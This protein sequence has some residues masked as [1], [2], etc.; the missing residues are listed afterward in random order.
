M[1]A[2]AAHLVQDLV[3]NGFEIRRASYRAVPGNGKPPPPA[4]AVA[5]AAQ[6]SL[7]SGGAL[8]MLVLSTRL[9]LSA[10]CILGRGVGNRAALS[11]PAPSEPPLSAA[12]PPRGR[13]D[14]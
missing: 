6:L 14:R 7:T 5:A 13:R 1:E 11:P 9:T 4:A 3:R 12:C 2:G 10:A 8:E